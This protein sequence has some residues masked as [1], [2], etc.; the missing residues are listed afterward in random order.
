MSETESIAEASGEPTILGYFDGRYARCFVALHPFFRIEG[1]NPTDCQNG[2]V[3]NDASRMPANIP[4]LEWSREQAQNAL[5]SK[6]LGDDAVQ[7]AARL[8]GEPISWAQICRGA[9]LT[10]HAALNLGLLTSIMALRDKYA[11]KT[12]A[13]QIIDYCAQQKIFHPTTDTFQTMMQHSLLAVLAATQQQRFI[14]RDEFG[15]AEETVTLDY[16]RER[17]IVPTGALTQ[18][19]RPVWLSTIDESIAIEVPYDC[20]F[21]LIYMTDAHHFDAV[22]ERWLEGFWCTT[23]TT[24][25]WWQEPPLPLVGYGGEA[26]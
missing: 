18:R 11:D 23:E 8:Y 26:R 15:F 5:G 21:T 9:G 24:I 14:M 25:D 10:H 1:L 17:G 7:K 6:I 12:L 3:I 4:L 20:F 13:A 2:P 16:L 22:I 19:Y